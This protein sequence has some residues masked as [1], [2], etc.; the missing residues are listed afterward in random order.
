MS[1]P[2]TAEIEIASGAA[3][4]NCAAY[5]DGRRRD[6]HLLEIPDAL[7]QEGAFVWIG[8]FE[9]DEALLKVVQQQFGLHDLA[10][11][12]A[13][14]AHQRPK[15]EQYGDSL[16]VVLRTAQLHSDRWQIDFGET[17]VFV[18]R[19]YLVTVRQGSRTSHVGLRARCEA[20]PLQLARGPGF[21]LYALMD[22]VVDQYFPVCERL[23]DELERLED[24]IFEGGFSRGTTQRIYE[25][26]RTVLGLKHAV[27]PLVDV[28][29]RLTRYDIDIIPEDTRP[30]FRDVYDHVVRLNELLDGV[31]ELLGTALEANLSLLSAKQNEDTKRL[32]AWAAIIALPTM[33]AGLYGMN[34]QFMPELQWRFGYPLALAM[35]VGGCA[36]LYA[37]FKRSGWL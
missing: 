13:H 36:A 23:E 15:L 22:F 26:K 14:T 37:M 32:A 1:G 25:L 6:L 21:I 27:L 2:S 7:K 33:V 28:C 34:F 29:S 5:V 18:G 24:D 30:Y 31:R 3:V 17:H 19:R 12:D 35:M 20:A 11:E 4:V 16:F 9:P 10:V 8:L